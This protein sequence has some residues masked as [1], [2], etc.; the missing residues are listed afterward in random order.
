MGPRT[1]TS[2]GTA[3]ALLGACAAA[4]C[5]APD[6]APGSVPRALAGG[7]AGADGAGARP[8]AGSRGSGAGGT[9]GSAGPGGATGGAGGA[10]DGGAP[11][12]DRGAADAAP[13]T[14]ADAAAIDDGG[15]PRLV[16]HGPG[17]RYATS[18]VAH[19]FGP[20]QSAG[21]DQ[22]PTPLLGPPKGGGLCQGSTDVV[23]LGNGG[24]V[25]VEFRGNAIL[26]RPGP[27]F[28][29]F[30]NAFGIGCDPNNVFAELG[31]VAVSEDG[32]TWLDFPCTATAPPYGQCSGSHPVFAN[33]D[34]NTIDPTDPALAGGDA[35]DLADVGL[36]T[37]RYVRVTDRPD[38]TGLSGVYDL[39]AVAIVHPECE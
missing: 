16:C 21:Q 36:G 2:L 22:L 35:Y 10:S 37:A 1:T 11:P 34:T 8:D 17:A 14:G 25:V 6:A 20:G 26:D 28:I 19:G 32:V 7:R 31:T 29:V 27:D 13:S 15:V 12:V 18:V 39:D 30:E 3:L 23:S 33:P 38:T 5:A 9:G 4:G 24:W